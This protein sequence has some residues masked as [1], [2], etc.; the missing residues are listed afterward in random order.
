M[1]AQELAEKLEVQGWAVSVSSCPPA[2]R[3]VLMPHIKR[4]HIIEFM[5]T[6]ENI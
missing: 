3:V 1:P 2:I 4:E 6:L 5:D